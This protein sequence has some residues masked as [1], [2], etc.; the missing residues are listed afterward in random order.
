MLFTCQ[1]LLTLTIL[2]CGSYAG[3]ALMCQIGIFP[4]MRQLTLHAYADSFRAI[5]RPMDRLTPPYKLS[6]LLINAATT[7]CLG[8]LHNT[9]MAA[10]AGLSL[11]LNIIALVITITKQLPL[12][13]QL[14]SLGPEAPAEIL[15]AIREQ[16]VRNFAVR[17]IV[18]MLA[19]VVLVV[20]LVFF[21]PH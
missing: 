10:A 5:D 11:V 1:L 12:N 14:K 16:T 8:L 6:L 9:Y 17:L 7:V 2:L 20:G 19:F 13:A 21:G 18:A 3:M 4:A 15:L